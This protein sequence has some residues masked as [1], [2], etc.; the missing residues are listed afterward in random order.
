ME[1]IKKLK[2]VWLTVFIAS[3]AVGAVSLVGIFVFATKLLYVPLGIC[4]A[5][6]AHAAYGCPFYFITWR[7]LT[8]AC[9]ALLFAGEGGL[10]DAEVAAGVGITPQLY[11][12]I[13]TKYFPSADDSSDSKDNVNKTE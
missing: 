8:L 1:K 7:N 12:K 2:V 11:E 3:A 9:K 5:L 10:S 13:K 6:T 4:I